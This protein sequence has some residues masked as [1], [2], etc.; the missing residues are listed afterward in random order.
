[1]DYLCAEGG[2]CVSTPRPGCIPCAQDGDC[3]DDDACTTNKCGEDG[4]CQFTTIPGCK[5]CT[6]ATDCDDAHS[7]TDDACVDGACE[8]QPTPG[9]TVCEPT[10][11]ICGDGIDND[12]NGLTDCDDPSCS[13]SAFCQKPKEICG[14]CID[15][16]GDGLVDYEDPDCCAETTELDLQGM[17]VRPESFAKSR[18]KRLR[19]RSVYSTPI[20]DGFDPMSADTQVQIRDD[21][22]ELFCAHIPASYW[23]HPHSKIFRFKDK[24]ETMTPGV[25]KS[26]FKL[27]LKKN[28]VRFGLVGKRTTIRDIEGEN[29]GMV[30]AVGD[31]CSTKDVE[32]R[33]GKRGYVYP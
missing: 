17:K 2:V 3:N 26:T 11:E 28:R 32:L 8:H 23:T 22:G 14:D 6:A 31:R 25:R 1:M 13:G 29:L 10:T 19:I 21:A 5:Q 9:C 27:R 24:T 16:D 20:P 18:G 7:C 33:A 4:S 12:C 30:V 15:N